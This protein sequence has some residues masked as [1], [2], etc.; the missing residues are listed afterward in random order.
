MNLLRVILTG[1]VRSVVKLLKWLL[2][3]S[4]NLIRTVKVY[5]LKMCNTVCGYCAFTPLEL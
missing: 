3:R 4:V 2:G 1:A 5:Q